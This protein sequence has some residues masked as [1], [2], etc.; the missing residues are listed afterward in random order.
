MDSLVDGP[1]QASGLRLE[2]VSSTRRTHRA[3]RDPLLGRDEALQKLG[4]SCHSLSMGTIAS[5][6]ALR[7][8]QQQQQHSDLM[9]G[10]LYLEGMLAVLATLPTLGIAEEV[11][12]AG[13]GT[14]AAT[15]SPAQTQ[16]ILRKATR[17]ALGGR[18]RPGGSK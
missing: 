10:R 6:A 1:Q 3:D 13:V 12:A 4:R 15:P 17:K 8:C 9:R 5:K 14:P 18:R 16:E 7:R 11:E 2:K